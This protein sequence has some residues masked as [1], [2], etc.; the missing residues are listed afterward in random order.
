[1]ERARRGQR[2]STGKT[3]REDGIMAV[4]SGYDGSKVQPIIRDGVIRITQEWLQANANDKSDEAEE[5][6]NSQIVGM[7]ICPRAYTLKDAPKVRRILGLEQAEGS[8]PPRPL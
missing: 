2:V 6:L 8:P 3:D 5:Y 1:M 7:S 4:G